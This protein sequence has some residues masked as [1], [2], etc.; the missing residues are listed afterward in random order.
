[1]KSFLLE[2]RCPGQG[3]HRDLGLLCGS[4]HMLSS[5]PLWCGFGAWFSGVTGAASGPC[6]AAKLPQAR[7]ALPLSAG[8]PHHCRRGVLTSRETERLPR[9]GHLHLLV[10]LELSVH[11]SWVCVQ[12]RNVSGL[13][14]KRLPFVAASLWPVLPALPKKSVKCYLLRFLNILM[15]FLSLLPFHLD[16][17]SLPMIGNPVLGFSSVSVSNGE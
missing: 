16:V 12:G 3:S 11:L 5:Q 4:N 17:G 15:A 1:M 10:P 8:L 2:S 6:W 14:T 7:T 9:M 13:G